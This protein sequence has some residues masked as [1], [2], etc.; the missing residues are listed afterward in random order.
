MTDASRPRLAVA[1]AIA[2]IAAPVVVEAATRLL[3]AWTGDAHPA[4]PLALAAIVPPLLAGAVAVLRGAA[5]PPIAW[6]LALVAAAVLFALATPIP[7]ALVAALLAGW[8]VS[9]I[10]RLAVHAPVPRGRVTAS[11]WA[12]L[13]VITIVQVG[14]MSVFLADPA[15]T[16]GTMAPNDPFMTRHSCLSSY[17]HGVELA[18][19]GDRNI[20]D[21]RY[22]SDEDAN[23]G[24]LA[25]IIDTGPLTMDTY[26]YPPQFLL[27]PGAITA[28]TRDFLAIRALWFLLSVAVVAFVG[29][30]LARW[31][32]DDAERRARLLV[33]VVAVSPPLLVTAYFGNFQLMAMALSAL[34]M[35]WIC[36]GH[37][38][39]GAALLGFVIGAKIFPGILGIWLLATRRFAAAAWTAAFSGLYILVTLAWLGTRPFTDFFTHHLPRLA[40]GE[41]FAFLSTPRASMSNLGVFGVPFKLRVAGLD[42]SESAAWT[43]ARQLSWGY[44]LALA[45]LAAW[46]GWRARAADSADDRAR[47]AGA[48]FG[49]LALAAL[50][51]PFAPP[52]AYIPLVWAL[53]LRAAAAPRRRD[54]AL[55]VVLWIAICIV[56]PVPTPGAAVVGLLLQ[57]VAYAAALALVLAATRAAKNAG[58]SGEPGGTLPA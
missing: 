53:A 37:T 57:A 25:P 42:I 40:S 7:L 46:A 38:R 2:V 48:W 56:I 28:L 31:L 16:W 27:L 9:A 52:E 21:D 12:L 20:Y 34:S 47:L 23:P 5:S 22:G 50:R 24:E 10:P 3:S 11:L 6:L 26:E 14:R 58:A 17:V 49:L 33:L 41:T 1:W 45:A 36:R 29:V 30:A 51:S 39:R 8:T 35:V 54:V 55:A 18:R 19:R 13:A 43:L 15:A 4:A 32:G 44:T